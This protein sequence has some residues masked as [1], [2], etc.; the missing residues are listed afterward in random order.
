MQD[1][2]VKK[3]RPAVLRICSECGRQMS[4]RE[5][6]KHSAECREDGR[7]A[8]KFE[9]LIDPHYYASRMSDRSLVPC[10]LESLGHVNSKGGSHVSA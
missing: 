8:R 7:W 4:T 2:A 3:G 1:C 10:S 6:H 9:Q 5:L